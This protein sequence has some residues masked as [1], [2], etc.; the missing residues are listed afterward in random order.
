MSFF[1]SKSIYTL[2]YFPSKK[3]SYNLS[4]YIYFEK[5]HDFIIYK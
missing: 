5:K 1:E 2:L 4:A 3:E